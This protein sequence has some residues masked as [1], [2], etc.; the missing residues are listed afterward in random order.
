[1]DALYIAFLHTSGK[2]RG[3]ARSDVSE[4]IRRYLEYKYV[5]E[6]SMMNHYLRRKSGKALNIAN[7]EAVMDCISKYTI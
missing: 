3:L 7:V 4:I 2:H 5:V 6:C 1:M